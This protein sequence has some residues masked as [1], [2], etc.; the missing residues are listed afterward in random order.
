MEERIWFDR[1]FD[2]GVPLRLLPE[3]VERLRG[4]PARVE[5]RIR[6]VMPQRLRERDG[7]NWSIQEQVGHLAD[8]EPLWLGRVDDLVE[9]RPVLREADLENR[10][11]WDARH[12]ERTVGEVLSDFRARRAELVRRIEG[13][14]DAG[15]GAT[16][17][18]PRLEQPMSIADLCLF[19]AE[20]DDHHLASITLLLGHR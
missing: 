10:A 1:T 3:L 6:D 9:G 14:D 17:L 16:A 20:H 4:T 2:L 11:T 15:R 5:E 13:L 8:L 12:N 7:E 19:V 18:H